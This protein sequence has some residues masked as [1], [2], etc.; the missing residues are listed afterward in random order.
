MMAEFRQRVGGQGGDRHAGFLGFRPQPVDGA[1]FDPLAGRIVQERIS[2]AEHAGLVS[3]GG[4]AGAG[5][6]VVERQRAHDR[7]SARIVPHGLERHFGRIRVPA[8]GMDHGGIDAAFVHQGDGFLGREMRHLPMR[9]VAGQ[10]GSPGVD[11]GVDDPHGV[12]FI[13][14][15]GLSPF[16]GEIYHFR[17][18]YPRWPAR[19][20][21]QVCAERSRRSSTQR[22]VAKLARPRRFELLTPR[23]VVWCSVQLSYGRRGGDL[24][25]AFAGDKAKYEA[26]GWLCGPVANFPCVG[27]AGR[28]P[29]ISTCQPA[30][31]SGNVL[32]ER[33]TPI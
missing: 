31:V 16:W 6:R 30:A 8:G 12:S 1:V 9:Q 29:N 28:A 32:I 19:N 25:Q 2:Q 5:G 20:T 10:A 21:V 7:E 24:A 27:Y 26:D 14:G 3:P 15:W 13:P 11:L 17:A 18:N 4:D 23:S 33:R 22:S